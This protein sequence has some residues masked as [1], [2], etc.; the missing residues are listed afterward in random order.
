MR[1]SGFV[2][3]LAVS[4]LVATRGGGRLYNSHSL[5]PHT[6]SDGVAK[7]SS[8]KPVFSS[9]SHVLCLDLICIDGGCAGRHNDQ[10][11]K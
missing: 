11:L 8:A 3:C 5:L 7:G 2:S 4:L 10:F 9:D 1:E 6:R